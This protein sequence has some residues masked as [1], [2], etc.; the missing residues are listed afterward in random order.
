MIEM[1]DDEILK[2]VLHEQMQQRDRVR[3]TG[4]ADEIA[5]AFRGMGEPRCHGV[6]ALAEEGL[7]WE[8]KSRELRSHRQSFTH[9]FAKTPNVTRKICTR[10]AA[11]S[12]LLG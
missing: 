9:R 10:A 1:A 6:E 7:Q 5:T 8:A 4:D 2:T 11:A 3:A 12:P